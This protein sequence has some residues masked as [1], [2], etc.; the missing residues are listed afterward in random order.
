MIRTVPYIPQFFRNKKVWVLWK[1]ETVKGRVTK[2]PYSAITGRKASSTNPETWSTYSE[3]LKAYDE[4]LGTSYEYNGLGVTLSDSLDCVFIDI[5][6]C[7]DQEGNLSE[8]AEDI[9]GK[10][11]YTY[12]EVSQSGT[13]IHLFVLGTIPRSF[14][15]SKVNVEMYK[16]GR[17]CAFTGNAVKP[18]EPSHNQEGL[19][20]VFNKYKTP[21]ITL[22]NE[23]VPVVSMECTKSDQEI[24]E[25]AMKNEKFSSLYS[26]KWKELYNSQSEADI[27][28]CEILAFWT[29]RDIEVIDRI[30]RSSGLYR[31]K[32][33]EKHGAQTYGEKT[34]LNAARYLPESITEWRKKRNEEVKLCILSE[35]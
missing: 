9:L 31:S 34:I 12:A 24:V 2:V 15:N 6:H 5:D 8:V 29:D 16:T 33:D 10:L 13:G 35:W 23:S 28:L 17:Y 19:D 32:W 27:A 18:C 11:K 4:C 1:L 20:Y 25:Q 3:C 7:I 30:F 21:D 26:G 14:K 22:R